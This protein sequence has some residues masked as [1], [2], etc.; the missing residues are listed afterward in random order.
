MTTCKLRKQ[1]PSLS[2]MK[3]KVFISRMVRAQPHTVTF[4][5]V[6][7]FL[8]GK[9]GSDLHSLHRAFLLALKSV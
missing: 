6:Q 3:P 1:E 2:S 5:A 9:K 7:L 8:V 4:L